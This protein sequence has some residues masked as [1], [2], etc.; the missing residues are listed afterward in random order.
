MPADSEKF[1]PLAL[2]ATDIKG[3]ACDPRRCVRGQKQGY[4][5]NILSEFPPN[6]NGSLSKELAS[7]VRMKWAALTRKTPNVECSTRSS[8]KEASL[9]D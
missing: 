6:P 8:S 9:A 4:L 3:M 5:G 1:S 7:T 2:A